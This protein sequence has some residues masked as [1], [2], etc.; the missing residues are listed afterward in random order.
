MQKLYGDKTIM[1]MAFITAALI[2]GIGGLVAF[3]KTDASQNTD[4][5]Y[6]IQTIQN[7]VASGGQL[8]DVRTAEEYEQ[9]HIDGA[10]NLSLQ[11]IQAG[12]M[13]SSAKDKPLYLYC[14]SGSRSSQA[15]KKLRAAGYQNVI[16]LGPMNS[17]QSIGGVIKT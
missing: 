11:D 1:K 13:P 5:S 3:N 15:A 9:A 17:V 8:L 16:D 6:G 12:T 4:M 10:A 14:R 7:D 2:L